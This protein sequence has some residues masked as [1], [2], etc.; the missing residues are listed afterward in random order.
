MNIPSINPELIIQYL[1][2]LIKLDQKAISNLID[3][4][5]PCNTD[6]AN[7]ETVQVVDLGT[8]EIPEYKV[9]ILGILNG[10]C[11]VDEDSFGF[12][13]GEFDEDN[14]T[15]IKFIHKKDCNK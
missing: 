2:N 10:L 3:A 11:G 6:L 1:N 4:R 5:V 12:I 8:D 14:K 7:H 9:G 13:V 15:I